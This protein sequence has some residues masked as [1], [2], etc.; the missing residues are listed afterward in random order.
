V[1]VAHQSRRAHAEA[2]HEELI[3]LFE[4]PSPD[5]APLLFHV[6]EDVDEWIGRNRA[7]L[8]CARGNGSPPAGPI[9]ARAP[10]SAPAG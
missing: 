5:E 2:E 7:A 6:A 9:R 4:P 1:S 8:T 3:A 10:P